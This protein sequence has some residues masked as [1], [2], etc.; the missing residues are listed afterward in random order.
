[1]CK[2]TI[3]D[4]RKVPINELFM[5]AIIENLQEEEAK[6]ILATMTDEERNR[7]NIPEAENELKQLA[8]EISELFGGTEDDTKDLFEGLKG[9]LPCFME[10]ILCTAVLKHEDKYISF[11]PYGPVILEEKDLKYMKPLSE[12]YREGEYRFIEENGRIV[13]DLDSL[14]PYKRYEN[15][16]KQLRN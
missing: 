14:E 9:I 6:E 15:E 2:I 16:V 8:P 11:S 7:S 12:Y 1:M 13:I 10:R 3:E 5:A 4:V